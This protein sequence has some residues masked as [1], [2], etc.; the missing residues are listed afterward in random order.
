V[1]DDAF[2]STDLTT[3]RSQAGVASYYYPNTASTTTTFA[4]NRTGRYIRVQLSGANILSLAEVQ[5]VPPPLPNDA[6]NDGLPDYFQDRNG[7]GVVNNGESDYT[8]PIVSITTPVDGSVFS[9]T[10]VNIHG[11]VT[12]NAAISRLTVN[13][14]LAYVS[15]TTF[16]ARNVMLSVG[17]NPIVVIA[18]DLGGNS[19]WAMVNVSAVPNGPTL[20]DPVQLTA[21]PTSGFETAGPTALNVTLQ[22]Q[23]ALP[24]TV[25]GVD[26]DFSGQG[27]NPDL[28]KPGLDLSSVS[29][30]YF[31]GEYLPVVTIRTTVGNFSSLGGFNSETAV[32][33]PLK[34]IVQKS[35]DDFHHIRFAASGLEGDARWK[36]VRALAVEP[37]RAYRIQ[38]SAKPRAN[39]DW[40]RD[41]PN[42]LG[43][44]SEWQCLRR[45]KR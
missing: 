5:V 42:R 25:L 39:G 27:G 14:V 19:G 43:R 45:C 41:P 10:R 36:P 20:T 31:A 8:A 9:T 18:T 15:G 21:T 16:D 4:I 40:G 13:G 29:H 34:V 28:T 17:A 37:F 7:D 1:T 2:Q 26:Y 38:R 22:A 44:G 24:G 6:N 32:T 11:T 33:T 35:T 23:A 3:T 30:G 12:A